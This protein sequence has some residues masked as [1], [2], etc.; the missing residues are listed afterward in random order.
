MGMIPEICIFSRLRPNGD[1]GFAAHI[2]D[3]KPLD[4]FFCRALFGALPLVIPAF[5]G[6]TDPGYCF[7]PVLVP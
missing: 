3:K 4:V 2:V 1:R 5:F 7:F 6:N